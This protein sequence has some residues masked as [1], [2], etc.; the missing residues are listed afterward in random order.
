M[1]LVPDLAPIPIPAVPMATTPATQGP[2][3]PPPLVV[4]R[5]GASSIPDSPGSGQSLGD[6]G[7]SPMSSAPASPDRAVADWMGLEGLL[8]GEG[9]DEG[10]TSGASELDI[11]WD[12]SSSDGSLA[13]PPEDCDHCDGRCWESR[14]PPQGGP[15]KR[16]GAWYR[17]HRQCPI[18]PG[19][20]TTVMQACFSMC[21]LKDQHRV[22]D[23]VV[24]KLCGYI[25]N[26]ILE[27]GNM[28]PPSFHLLKAVAGVPAGNSTAVDLCD[29]C[30]QLYPVLSSDAPMPPVDDACRQCGAARYKDALNGCRVPRRQLFNFGARQT[31][32]DLITKPGM[33][34][35]VLDSRRDA[36]TQQHSF[37][38]SP[39]GRALNDAC[40][41][42]FQVTTPPGEIPD[43]MA[44]AF[45][46]GADPLFTPPVT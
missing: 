39:A 10:S 33:V 19:H 32:V 11:L 4:F 7:V 1:R 24:N 9:L 38:G 8:D 27:P 5:S 46:L 23:V 45:C 22:P 43:E 18:W 42:A 36:W 31:V 40:G 41:D 35:A 37:W 15:T 14:T 21:M 34:E 20:G 30:W 17:Y 3:S 16:S 6:V 2:P 44:I 13:E 29:R 25:H 26:V 28:F 12:A